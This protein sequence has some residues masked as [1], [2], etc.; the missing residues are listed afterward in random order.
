MQIK[1]PQSARDQ[2]RSR[3]RFQR[4]GA[5]SLR[6]VAALP[7]ADAYLRFAPRAVDVVV[8]DVP[9]VPA[10][11]ILDGK[12]ATRDIREA[13]VE[14]PVALV[15]LERRLHRPRGIEA[16]QLR[17]APPAVFVSGVRYPLAT[18]D[19]AAPARHDIVR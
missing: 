10:D 13:V 4:V 2:Q 18:D 6:P 5:I 14:R 8:H 15:V 12:R 9:D 17:I 19:S 7:D 1:T 16:R 3:D 11:L